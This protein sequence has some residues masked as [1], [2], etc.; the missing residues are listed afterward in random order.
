MRGKG[1]GAE[2]GMEDRWQGTC[3]GRQLAD[4]GLGSK[5]LVSGPLPLVAAFLDT[6]NL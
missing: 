3:E 2:T 6:A 1:A 5:G 4:K